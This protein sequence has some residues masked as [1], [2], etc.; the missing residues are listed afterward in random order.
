MLSISGDYAVVGASHEDGG[1]ANSLLN[2][3][4]AYFY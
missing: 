2:A 1:P 3:G 4:A